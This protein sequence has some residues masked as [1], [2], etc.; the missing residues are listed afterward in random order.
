MPKPRRFALLLEYDGTSYA[1]SQLQATSPT[2]QSVLED[3]VKRAT[4][5]FCRVAFAGR[6]D[7]GVH[8][9]GQVASFISVTQLEPETLVRALNAH[10][11]SDVAVQ[12]A[13]YVD[14]DFDPR[15][16]AVRRMYRYLIEN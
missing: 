10:L 14:D 5:V 4:G 8:A 12:C 1:G 6:T 13:A 3:A 7:A 16:Q 11:P 9:L 2:V 15:R